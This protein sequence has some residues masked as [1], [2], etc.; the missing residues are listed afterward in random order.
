MQLQDA[1]GNYVTANTT[2][3]TTTETVAVTS[4]ITRAYR[5]SA[6]VLVMGYSEIT[7]GTSTTAVTQRI[8]RGTAI[9]DTLVTEANALQIQTAAASSE[10]YSIVCFEQLSQEQNVQY[11]LTLQQTAAAANGTILS[12]GIAILII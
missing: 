11:S 1:S 10:H 7:L 12:A 5:N 8:R 4:P 2:V 3:T 6:I 9:T